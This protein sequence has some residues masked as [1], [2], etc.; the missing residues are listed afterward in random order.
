MVAGSTASAKA[1][2]RLHQQ[3][4]ATDIQTAFNLPEEDVVSVP[5]GSPGLDILLSDRAR[6]VFPFGVEAKRQETLSIPSWWRQCSK[7]AEAAGL[8]PLLVYRKS[9][10]E[11]MA[12]MR[13]SDFILLA[14][15]AN[16]YDERGRKGQ[17]PY[18]DVE[19]YYKDGAE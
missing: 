17:I 19:E 9:R 6:Q 4:I 15:K 11:G 14:A 8:K 1:K 16:A 7:N 2:S 13:W 3:A 5:M 10:E 18:L 12:V